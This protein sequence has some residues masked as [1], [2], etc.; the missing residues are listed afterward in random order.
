[1]LV[2]TF[3]FDQ[4]PQPGPQAGLASSQ[5]RGLTGINIAV[6]EYLN[7]VSGVAQKSLASQSAPAIMRIETIPNGGPNAAA[8]NGI[9]FAT[10]RSWPPCSGRGR[11]GYRE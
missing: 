9:H 4:S 8:A 3:K 1:M 2:S 10:A 7:I 5:Q 11:H 6:R